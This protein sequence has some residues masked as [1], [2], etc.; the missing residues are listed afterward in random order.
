LVQRL[1][2]VFKSQCTAIKPLEVEPLK[3][4]S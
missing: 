4:F 2:S 3:L 1:S